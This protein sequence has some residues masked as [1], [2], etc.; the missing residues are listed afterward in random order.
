MSETTYECRDQ[1]PENM[2]W[3][4]EDIFSTD[5]EWESA[6]RGVPALIEK[7]RTSRKCIDSSDSLL[8]ALDTSFMMELELSE[9]YSYARMRRDENNAESKYQEMTGRVMDLY[10]KAQ[11]EQ[12]SLMTAL[13]AID[14]SQVE[15][16]LEEQPK[17]DVYTHLL[18][19]IIRRKPHILSEA[20]EKILSRFGSVDQGIHDTY[21]M[22]DNVDIKLGVIKDENGSTIKLTPGRFAQLRDHPDRQ[23][24]AEA[25]RRMHEAYAEMGN[26]L[27]T[28]YSTRVKADLLQS[29]SRGYQDTLSAALFENNLPVSLYQGL[30]DAVHDSQPIMKRYFDLR[31][32]QL[33]LDALHI[34]DTYIPI[35]DMPQRRY[36][37]QQ[38]CDLLRR[39]L[40]PLGEGYL[41]L[42]ERHL[43][44]RWID[45]YETPGKTSGAYSWGTYRSHPYVLMNF[46]GTLSDVFTLAHE[47]GHSLHTW[48][49][50]QRPFAVSQYPIFLA[51][52]AST[53]NENLLLQAMLDDCDTQTEAGRHEEKYLLNHFLES[54]RLTVF[55]QTMFAEFEWQAQ[56]AAEKGQALTAQALCLMYA[57]LLKSYFEPAVEV[58]DFMHWEWARIPHFYSSYYVY[59]YA[60][61][62]SAA[63]AISR[64]ILQDGSAAI[65]R[66]LEFLGSGGSDYPLILLAKTG[67]DLSGS[68]PVKDAMA[69]FD[70]YLKRLEDLF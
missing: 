36:T 18:D 59:Q 58:D 3:K 51:E 10:F 33:S 22:L 69:V 35:V 53:V 30:I 45:V 65:A 68:G 19:D 44:Q 54:M 47:V 40:A 15:K 61:G 31:K 66:Y 34:Y 39:G 25:F 38:A 13:A 57:D 6:C 23:V 55:R 20:E 60:T 7:V 16:W 27:A 67:V 50:S 29:E 70:A 49:S 62:F 5:A 28:L 24:R 42:L 63:V 41:A 37:W 1:I 9:L 48:Y 21:T 56:Q 4:L 26:T 14:S 17:L 64:Q 8:A 43:T 52:I 32:K 46:S 11:E 12:A 2:R